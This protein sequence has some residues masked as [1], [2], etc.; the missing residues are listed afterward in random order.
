MREGASSKP[1]PA[2][3]WGPWESRT[4]T[5]CRVGANRA[6]VSGADVGHSWACVMGQGQAPRETSPAASRRPMDQDFIF[7]PNI[8]LCDSSKVGK[9]T[10]LLISQRR[11]TPHGKQ[12][13]GLETCPVGGHFNGNWPQSHRFGESQPRCRPAPLRSKKGL[14]TQR[15]VLCGVPVSPHK[16]PTI[17]P[18]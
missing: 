18:S 1:R 3:G 13:A 16:T 14:Q 15:C 9:E 17:T 2:W 10:K 6:W 8:Q 12:T 4:R 7:A 11:S 5:R